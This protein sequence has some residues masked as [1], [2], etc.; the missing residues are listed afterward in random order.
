MTGHALLAVT[1]VV[2]AA[3]SI[4]LGLAYRRYAR[5][6]FST[7]RRRR[8]SRAMV[9]VGAAVGVVGYGWVVA[10]VVVSLPRVAGLAPLTVGVSLALVAVVPLL[11][12]T[13]LAVPRTSWQ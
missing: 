2:L 6:A 10:S 8:I 3:L 11:V 4:W 9:F 13:L 1:A 12:G 5:T 7:D